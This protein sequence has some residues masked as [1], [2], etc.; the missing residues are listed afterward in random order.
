MV[1]KRQPLTWQIVTVERGERTYTGKF[2]VD[3][4]TIT[5]T[6]LGRSRS[7]HVGGTPADVLARLILGE[8]VPK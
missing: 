4:G 1:R 2:A 6:Y 5:V 7:T 8:L 3:R